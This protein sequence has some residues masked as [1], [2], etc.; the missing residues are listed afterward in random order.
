MQAGLAFDALLN[1]TRIF[2]GKNMGVKTGYS[3]L[4]PKVSL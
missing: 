4:L 1:Y 3:A 2:T